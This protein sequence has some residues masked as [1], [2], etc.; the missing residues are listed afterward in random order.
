[1]TRTN[2]EV[3]CRFRPQNE[4]E[5]KT[6]E[7]EC[8]AIESNSVKIAIDG[9]KHEFSFDSVFGQESTQT[10]LFERVG[11][12]VVESKSTWRC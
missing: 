5:R 1:M 8:I 7:A 12:P 2:I 11:K 10:E 6:G 9:T 3:I 4:L